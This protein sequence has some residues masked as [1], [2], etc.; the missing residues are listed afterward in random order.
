MGV[1][2][3]LKERHECDYGDLKIG[4]STTHIKN[5]K[6]KRICSRVG[7]HVEHTVNTLIGFYSGWRRSSY[8]ITLI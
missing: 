5:S 6:E 1:A 4:G 2:I 7:G 8:N 3:K